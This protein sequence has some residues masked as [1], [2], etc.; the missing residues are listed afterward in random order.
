LGDFCFYMGDLNYRLKSSFTELNNTNVRDLAISWIPTKDQL[1]EA[2][3]EGYYPGYAEMPITFIPS[4]K[5]STNEESYVNKKDQAPS[6]CDRCLF[7]NNLLMEYTSDFYRC[8]HNCHGSDHRPVQLGITLKNFGQ[9]RFQDL[10]RLVNTDVP[11]QGYGELTVKMVSISNF[12]FSKSFIL[13]KFI[14]PTIT[15]AT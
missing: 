12:D 6:Y 14:I 4:Y 7:K 13:S 2:M 1:V 3:S 5:M 10:A 11:R 9:P 8:I 15:D